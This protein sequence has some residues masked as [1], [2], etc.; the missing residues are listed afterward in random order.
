[1]FSTENATTT[2]NSSKMFGP[3]SAS[4]LKIKIKMGLEISPLILSVTYCKELI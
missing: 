4:K 2:A 1:M 3:V